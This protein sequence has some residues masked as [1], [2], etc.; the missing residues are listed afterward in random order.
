MRI[1]IS[2]LCLVFA[3]AFASAQTPQNWRT[4][5]D[6]ALARL[7]VKDTSGAV[8]EFT[9]MVRGSGDSAA[10]YL[11]R[12]LFYTTIQRYD[13]AF[14]DF[15][16]AVQKD[17]SNTNI[18][19]ARGTVFMERKQY[20][21]AVKDFSECIVLNNDHAQAYYWRGMVAMRLNDFASA[22]FDLADALRLD[23]GNVDIY[24]QM[25]VL[26]TKQQ[27]PN[28]ALK[29][30]TS[31]LGIDPTFAQ[32]Y[33]VRAGVLVDMG[34]QQEACKDLVESVKLGFKP[35]LE[36][37][38]VQCGQQMSVKALDS[39]QTYVMQEV[40]VVGEREEYQRAARE[41]KVIAQRSR[42][43]ASTLANRIS[44]SAK[45]QRSVRIR[46]MFSDSASDERPLVVGTGTLPITSFQNVESQ[47]ASKTNLD[48]FIALTADRVAMSNNAEAQKAMNRI[49]Q[50]RNFL[51]TLL[52]NNNTTEARAVIQEIATEIS[53]IA[54][55]LNKDATQ[56]AKQ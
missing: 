19:L 34:K 28:D 25:A 5:T 15:A 4:Y 32:A 55:I 27:R 24:F 23:S 42:A 44:L 3:A 7:L 49:I 6:R 50:R 22:E 17:P 18:F 38:R 45:T 20:R 52:D 40:T 54:D 11:Q 2:T 46:G 56:Q 9:A 21:E 30:L 12:S 1:L 41:M 47:R 35:A 10:A 13:S 31:A 37:L 36:M 16:I 8:R 26:A 39:L 29:A 48:D 33:M 51:R 43:I 14:A 53:S